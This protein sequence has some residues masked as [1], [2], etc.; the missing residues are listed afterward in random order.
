MILDSEMVRW[1]DVSRRWYQR[2]LDIQPASGKLHHHLGLLSRDC[3]QGEKEDLRAVYHFMKRYVK[4]PRSPF[5]SVGAALTV[6]SF[7]LFLA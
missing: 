3:D 7:V 6:A 4:E 5:D 2:G 1:R